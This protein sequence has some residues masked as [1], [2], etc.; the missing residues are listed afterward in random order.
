[1]ALCGCLAV[2]ACALR[3]E[4]AG[5]TSPVPPD[6]ASLAERMGQYAHFPGEFGGDGSERDR[7]VAAAMARLRCDALEG[8]LAAARRRHAG[9]PAVMRALQRAAVP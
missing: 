6:I 3:G 8:D 5:G 4:P 2:A 7:Q 9:E 1:M